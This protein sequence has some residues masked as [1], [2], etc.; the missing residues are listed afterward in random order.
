M[1]KIKV[2]TLC[3]LVACLLTA[4]D[5][6]CGFSHGEANTTYTW[7]YSKD[8]K[9]SSGEFK[10]NEYGQASFDVPDGTDC[11]AVEVKVKAGGHAGLEE[12]PID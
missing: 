12:A 1:N 10:T 4:C 6:F 7:S 3:A 9:T 5:D 8:G 2:A 11:N